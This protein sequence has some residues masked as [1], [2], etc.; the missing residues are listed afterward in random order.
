MD[1][2]SGSV[3]RSLAKESLRFKIEYIKLD[4][5]ITLK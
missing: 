5:V 3:L 4:A 2:E 1:E